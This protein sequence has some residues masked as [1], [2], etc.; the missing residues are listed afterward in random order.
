MLSRA[1]IHKAMF[2][3]NPSLSPPVQHSR[4]ALVLLGCSRIPPVQYHPVVFHPVPCAAF[5]CFFFLW[6]HQCAFAVNSNEE[7][8]LGGRGH[9]TP[10][11]RSPSSLQMS[12]VS[13][14][15]L[16]GISVPTYYCRDCSLGTSCF[17]STAPV[18][19][20][21]WEPSFLLPG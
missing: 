5:V 21:Q 13:V 14:Q 12:L 4:E 16:G 8:R 18:L 3:E 19:D 6:G 11:T 2:W 15:R 10:F 9:P 7:S 20:G 17:C 1:G